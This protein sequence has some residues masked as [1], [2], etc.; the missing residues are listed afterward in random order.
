MIKNPVLQFHGQTYLALETYRK[1]GQG[2]IT[3]VW[4]YQEGDILYVRTGPFSGKTKRIRNNP[5][6]KVVPSDGRG[7]PS[8]EWISGTANLIDGQKVFQINEKMKEKYGLVKW[9]FDQL[10]MI[11]KEDPITLEINISGLS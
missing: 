7:N 1:N 6:V 2:V 3:P 10:G 5:S 4:F 8:G 9:L 11:R